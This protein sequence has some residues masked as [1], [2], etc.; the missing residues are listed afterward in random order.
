MTGIWWKHWDW[1][2]SPHPEVVPAP[3]DGATAAF[4]ILKA[5]D[6]A[7]QNHEHAPFAWKFVVDLQACIAKH[8][9]NSL[10]VTQLLWV[11]NTDILAPYDITHLARVMFSPVQY[12]IFESTWRH[13]VEKAALA[14][15]AVDQNDPRRGVGVNIAMSKHRFDNPQCK[16]GG[17]LQFGNSVNRSE[18]TR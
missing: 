3:P 10:E 14:N 15:M 12:S 17:Q 7:G 11:V 18:C 8:G 13:A 5:A 6:G 1:T 9:L 16:H 4:P 2:T